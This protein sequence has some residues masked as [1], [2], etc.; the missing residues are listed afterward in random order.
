MP[1]GHGSS[2]IA[3]QR[4]IIPEICTTRMDLLSSTLDEALPTEPR[5]RQF[6]AKDQSNRVDKTRE[7]FDAWM[8]L[9]YPVTSSIRTK[10]PLACNFIAETYRHFK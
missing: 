3:L 6:A 5:L 4:D 1:S 7:S 10:N 9:M 8:E 2:F